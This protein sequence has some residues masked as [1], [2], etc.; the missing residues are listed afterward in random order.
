M[1]L[2]TSIVS[3][4]CGVGCPKP[5][6]EKTVMWACSNCREV[7]EDQ[8][9]ACWNCGFSREGKLNL[10][11]MRE[12]TAPS[13]DSSLEEKLRQQA[14]NSRIRSLRLAFLAIMF[15]Q[16]A[17]VSTFQQNDLSAH[18]SGTMFYVFCAVAVVLSPFM[19]LWVIG[20]QI[21]VNRFS[22][23]RW[24]LPT[25]DSNPLQLT[26]PLPVAH[27]ASQLS[28]VSGAGLLLASIW[29]GWHVCLMGLTSVLVGM[30]WFLGLLWCIRLASDKIQPQSGQPT[31]FG[32]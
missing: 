12:P 6:A 28:V 10:D 18:L 7:I 5:L 19:M 32:R 4:K 26:N 16:S 24:E 25:S 14:A 31:M 15:I 13:D 8:F 9:D 2:P 17:V 23:S 27:F 1:S 30:G 29:C 20:I 3:F 21:V 11:F 22:D